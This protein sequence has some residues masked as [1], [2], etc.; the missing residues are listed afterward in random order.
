MWI[1]TLNAGMGIQVE[2]EFVLGG[3]G[4]VYTR[5]WF[6]ISISVPVFSTDRKQTRVMGLLHND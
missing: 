6:N 1:W 4:R 5:P 3:N 2:V